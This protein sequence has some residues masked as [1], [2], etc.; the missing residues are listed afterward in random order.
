[1]TKFMHLFVLCPLIPCIPMAVHASTCPKIQC[2]YVFMTHLGAGLQWVTNHELYST[3]TGSEDFCSPVY[4][5][6]CK[7]GSQKVHSTHN[8]DSQKRGLLAHAK[9]QKD[10]GRCTDT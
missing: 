1:M 5:V 8:E 6:D 10:L 4:C 3:S 2:V 9:N 7:D